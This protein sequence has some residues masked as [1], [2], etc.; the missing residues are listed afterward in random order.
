MVGKH[1]VKPRQGRIA[2]CSAALDAATER[3]RTGTLGPADAHH[4]FDELLQQ[5]TPVPGQALNG[6]LAALARAPASTACKDSPAL[7]VSLFNRLRREASPHAS[8]LTAHTYSILMDCC[9]RARRPDLGLAFF[10]R[11]LRTGLRTDG[12]DAYAL[13]RCFCLAKR[14]DK[15]VSV[16]LH[17]MPELGCAPDAL[18]YSVVLKVLCDDG[19]SQRAL[20]LPQMMSKEGGG[21]APNVVAYST[22]IHGFCK[23]GEAHSRSSLAGACPVHAHG[24]SDH[25][26]SPPPPPPR[27]PI[28]HPSRPVLLS[29]LSPGTQPPAYLPAVLLVA[30]APPSGKG[31]EYRPSFADDF[32]LAFFRAKMVERHFRMPGARGGGGGGG[33][34]DITVHV[35]YLART[36]MQKQRE[37]RPRAMAPSHRLSRVPLHLRNNNAKDYTPGFV[38]IGPLHSREDRRLRPAER[39][40]VA[41]LNSLISRGHPDTAQHLAVIQGYIRVVAA[42]EQEARA[43]YVGEDVA[44]IPPD[45]FIQMMVLDGCFIIEHLINVATGHEEPSLH[46]TP[47]GPAQLSVDLVLAENQ[48]PFFVL[49]DLIA[50]TKLPEFEATGYPSPVLLVKLVLYYLA[51]EKGRDMSEELPPAEGV[52]HVLHLLHAMIT[53]ARTRWEPP[54]RTIQDGA[55]IE[56]AQEAARLLRRIPLLLFV[57]LLYPILPEDKKWSASYGKEDVP[58]ASD[59]KRMGVQFKKARAG[60]GSKAVAGIASVLG[61]VPL[62]LRVEFR[63]A[64]LLL[65]LMAF[66]QSASASMKTPMDVSAYVCFMAK[67]VQSA[68]DAGVLAA[69]EKLR[70][71]SRHP[72]YVMWADVQRNYFTLPWAVVI[73]VVALVTFVSTMV[74]TYT[75]VKYHS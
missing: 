61:P 66:E 23:E 53:A 20:D 41:Y 44:E 7:A 45:E 69:A 38:A 15:A 18:S 11:L 43:M 57:P 10:G 39:L 6:F 47:F 70:E 9:C 34:G 46:A 73:E 13:I 3:V 63:T 29:P 5:A 4:L 49:V 59:L 31:G 30:A 60:S 2:A 19:R 21:C 58:A 37:A 17:R 24:G 55:V 40:K 72:L 16:L 26:P 12:I 42:R 75:S 67:M 56:T 74:Q 35:E 28:L 25:E 64:P 52:S 62:A 54:P 27:T 51:G 32:L 1:L 22:V 36:L 14:T 68:E 50:S 65:N 8:P 33:G 48:M 71:R